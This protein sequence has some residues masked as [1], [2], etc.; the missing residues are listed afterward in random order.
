MKNKEGQ[1]MIFKNRFFI[2]AVISLIAW[3]IHTVLEQRSGF[4]GLLFTYMLSIVFLFVWISIGILK[5]FIIPVIIGTVL[6]FFAPL[7]LLNFLIW[8]DD[9]GLWKYDWPYVR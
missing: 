6:A 8:G 3:G 2:M 5:L 7:L 1:V 4:V 9:K